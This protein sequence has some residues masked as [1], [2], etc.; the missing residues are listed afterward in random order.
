MIVNYGDRYLEK[1]LIKGVYLLTNLI[2]KD[3]IY[4]IGILNGTV[5]KESKA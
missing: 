4:V 3:Y 5:K 2:L 1:P